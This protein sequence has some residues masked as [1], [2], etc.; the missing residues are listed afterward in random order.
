LGCAERLGSGESCRDLPRDVQAA[1]ER[2][3]SARE[4]LAQAAPAHVFESQKDRAIRQ[5]TEID[6]RRN[7]RVLDVGGGH[8]FALE[9]LDHFRHIR[10]V[11][12]QDLDGDLLAQ[13]HVLRRV[14]SAGAPFADQQFDSIAVRE[15]DARP[16]FVGRDRRLRVG[17]SESCHAATV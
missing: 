2:E 8:G 17:G 5:A 14:D 10:P 15:H 12:S 7:V 13:Q 4:L 3:R 6:R 1:S 16:H 9:A 11:A